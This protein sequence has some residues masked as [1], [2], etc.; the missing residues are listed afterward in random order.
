ML[1]MKELKKKLTPYLFQNDFVLYFESYWKR[2]NE[3][4]NNFWDFNKLNDW[5]FQWKKSDILRLT[6]WNVMASKSEREIAVDNG[7]WLTHPSH[8][9]VNIKRLV[10]QCQPGENTLKSWDR[11]W[12]LKLRDSRQIRE[13]WLVC[14]RIY[15]YLKFLSFLP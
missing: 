4:D 1:Q 2:E 12:L 6:R 15:Y 5:A 13:T 7:M 3:T 10:A 11:R 9:N 14:K 8:L